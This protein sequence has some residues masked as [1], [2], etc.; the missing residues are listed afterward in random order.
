[1]AKRVRIS[2]E[3]SE[4]F[5]RLLNAKVQLGGY[6]DD[7]RELGDLTSKPS[8]ASAACSTASPS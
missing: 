3:V 4:S 2:I 5:I 7:D 1:M 8:I 6:H